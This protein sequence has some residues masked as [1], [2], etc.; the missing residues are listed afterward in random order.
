MGPIGMQHPSIRPPRQR[1]A[2]PHKHAPT[3]Q[4]LGNP[5]PTGK[6]KAWDGDVAFS[7]SLPPP[8]AQPN[9]CSLTVSSPF[10]N[11]IPNFFST[12]DKKIRDFINKSGNAPFSYSILGLGVEISQPFSMA[13]VEKAR[14]KSSF[15]H[16]FV[17][18]IP[19]LFFF[20]SC[21][22]F[23]G[24]LAAALAVFRV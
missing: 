7:A 3:R 17:A 24:V 13:F 10:L 4:I 1:R 21:S 22:I 5:H 14:Q 8:R 12:L 2:R 11:P 9:R 15:S 19:I 18:Q 20:K 23:W 6:A 16:Y